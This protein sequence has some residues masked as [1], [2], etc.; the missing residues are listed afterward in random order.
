MIFTK[1]KDKRTELEKERDRA[2]EELKTRAWTWIDEAEVKED[3]KPKTGIYDEQLRRI[4]RLNELI[5]EKPKKGID[6]N[7]ALVVLGSLVEILI[8]I[9]YEKVGI[10]TS[11]AFN[12]ILRGRA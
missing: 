7:T 12:R 5:G 10:I 11:K 6:L 9:N 2:I 3:G 8:I 1:R 4:E